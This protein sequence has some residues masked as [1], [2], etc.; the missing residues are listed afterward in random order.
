MADGV[1]RQPRPTTKTERLAY[2]GY[3]TAARVVCAL[4][5]RIAFGLAQVLGRILYLAMPGRRHMAERHQRRITGASGPRLRSQVLGV[6]RSYAR[7]WCEFFRLPVEARR[8]PEA[9]DARF[10]VD[11]F[12][13]IVEGAARGRG[14]ILALPHVG[15]WEFA[16]A[17]LANHGFPPTV[18]AER[19][20]PPELYEFFVRQRTE[21]GM[22]VIA[23]G[24]NASAHLLTALR[25]NRV[26]CL[27][28]DRDI[29]RDG[30]PVMFFGEQTT[31]PSGP[32]ALA[33]RTGATLLPVAVY[34]HGRYGHFAQVGPPLNTERAGSL[35]ADTERLT[36]ALAA[37]FEELIAAAPDEWHVLQ[38][39]WPSDRTAD[40]VPSSESPSVGG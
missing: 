29:R 26:V 38:P 3:T 36:Q 18:V 30:I 33:L 35:R 37:R 9:L 5:E 12:D 40:E 8:G 1:H 25:A 31:M 39:T 32:A 10:T 28:A 16:G 11:G 24:S 21:L 34:F 15:G 6:F 13:H 22:E 27:L 2:Y 4:P 17:W 14:V 19:V 23:L 20:R 7:Y